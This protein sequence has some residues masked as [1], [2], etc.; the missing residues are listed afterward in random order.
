MILLNSKRSLNKASFFMQWYS[1]K[2][3]VV[4]GIARQT[5]VRFIAN[6]SHEYLWVKFNDF[7]RSASLQKS[8]FRNN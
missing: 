2:G 5:W 7:N 1:A 6:I 3:C 4:L 8:S